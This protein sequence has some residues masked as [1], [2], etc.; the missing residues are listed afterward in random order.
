MKK[1]TKEEY[2]QECIIEKCLYHITAIR[3]LTDAIIAFG[4]EVGGSE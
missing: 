4:Q 1:P 2:S 3:H